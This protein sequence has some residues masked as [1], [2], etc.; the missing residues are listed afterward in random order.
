MGE[1]IRRARQAEGRTTAGA[2]YVLVIEWLGPNDRKTGWELVERLKGWG[3]AAVL[4]KCGSSGDV[5][6]A[7][8]EALA[9]ARSD[10][11]RPILHLEAHGIAAPNPGDPSGLEGPDGHGGYEQLL[12]TEVAPV[13]GEI[14]LATE[15]Q[16]LLVGAACHSLT[17]LD[18]FAIGGVSPFSA[19]VAFGNTVSERGLF[20][21]MVELYRQLLTSGSADVPS[22]VNS[23]N[24]QLVNGD[25]QIITFSFLWFARSVIAGYVA[26]EFEPVQRRRDNRRLS[27][28]LHL[29]G[30][31][32]SDQDMAD[33]HRRVAFE[34][35]RRA[36][37]TWFAYDQFPWSRV[38]NAI[39]VRQI[40][41]DAGAE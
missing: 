39:D 34:H 1:A 33:R 16:L 12:W 40:F 14:N 32:I 38:A 4:R 36:V 41:R 29:S 10:G 6:T 21:S 2:H 17:A 25:G 15:L 30:Q 9:A 11:L 28:I 27:N 19:V 5:R 13:L 31:P 24:R 18:G 35:C 22:A 23:A 7:L 3:Q 26:K 37:A 8:D 20:E